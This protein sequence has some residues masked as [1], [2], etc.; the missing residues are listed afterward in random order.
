MAT[1]TETTVIFGTTNAI[2]VDN[3]PTPTTWTS[4]FRILY[5]PGLTQ[6]QPLGPEEIP[7]AIQSSL[8]PPV[9]STSD[10][11]SSSA[12]TSPSTTTISS[13]ST[14]TNT[15]TN[16]DTSAATGNSSSSSSSSSSLNHSS[17]SVSA[18]STDNGSSGHSTG[19][20]AGAAV[21]CAIG[22]ILIGLVAAWLLLHRRR[23]GQDARNTVPRDDPRAYAAVEKPSPTISDDSTPLN[24]L[25]LDATPDREIEAEL[26]ALGHLIDQHVEKYYH[27]DPISDISILSDHLAPLGDF[28][29]GTEAIAGV[30]AKPMSRQTG[31]RHVISQVIF[32]SLDIYSQSAF[33]LLPTPVGTFL[34]SVPSRNVTAQ[35]AALSEWRRLSAFLLHPNPYDRTPLPISEAALS[36]QA[37]TLTT[38]LNGFLHHFV[39]TS[40]NAQTDHLQAVI[41]E[42]TKLGYVILSQPQDWRFVFEKGNSVVVCPG[43]DKGGRRVVEP[44]VGVIV[45]LAT[46]Q[47]PLSTQVSSCIE[48]VRTC[49]YDL[50]HLVQLRN[51]HATLLL[52]TAVERIDGIIEAAQQCHERVDRLVEK[53]RPEAHG[54]KTPLRSKMRWI[55]ADSLDFESQQPLLHC[56]HAAVLAELNFVRQVVLA[57]P[58]I[59]D[60]KVE[61]TR[62]EP[63]VISSTFSNIALLG[64]VF[65]SIPLAIC[66]PVPS[67]RLPSPSISTMRSC[68]NSNIQSLSSPAPTNIQR[69]KKSIS[70]VEVHEKFS[71]DNQKEQYPY[72]DEKEV[73]VN[74]PSRS[75]DK[76][77]FV[78]N[79]QDNTGLRLL[80]DLDHDMVSP[81]ASPLVDAPSL[82]SISQIS[83]MPSVP[84]LHSIPLSNSSQ[85]N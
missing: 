35:S 44:E 46:D 10:P 71:V 82:S 50:Q 36:S 28:P 40:H 79:L 1:S 64:D 57:T 2:G 34:D 62:Q 16:T 41:V 25:L 15:D 38:R 84:S 39:G 14:G 42:C 37:L 58:A 74:E 19:A 68:D 78:L 61:E 77:R 33:S 65:D 9:S 76:D 49:H 13:T 80:F 17:T 32:R 56:H 43:L 22:G 60:Q 70:I 4:G 27:L 52:P 7:T 73:V 69:H 85:A 5:G 66:D 30:C 26:Q 59:E 11:A 72:S 67:P 63:A 6:S 3:Q 12:G 8:N 55:L 45:T 21:G 18:P 31:L 48:L 23:K 83:S 51:Q 75:S 20:L 29:H 47:D 53:C 24:H 54:G 81:V